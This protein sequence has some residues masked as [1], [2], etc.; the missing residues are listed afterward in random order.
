MTI[1]LY[2]SPGSCSLAPHIVLNEVGQPFELRKFATADRANYSPDYLA[3]NPKGRIP[4]LQI[5]GFI[6][7]ENPAILAYLGR[8]FPGAGL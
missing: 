7:T 4:A 3:V 6:L 8:K 1:A 5:D 2:Y